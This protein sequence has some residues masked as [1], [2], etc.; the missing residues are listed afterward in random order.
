MRLFRASIF[1][2]ILLLFS[3]TFLT[4]QDGV[5]AN[6]SP[7]TRYGVGSIANPTFSAQQMMGGWSAA[8]ASPFFVNMENPAS[9]GSLGYTSFES[10]MFY[11]YSRLSSDEATADI[12]DGNLLHLTLAF[13]IFNPINRSLAA[14]KKPFNWGMGLSLAPY[15]NVGY[16]LESTVI[17]P[18]VGEVIYNF[19]GDGQ[20]YT[21]K[22]GNG[23]KYKNFSVGANLGYLFGKIT[24]TRI[25][26]FNDV[27]AALGNILADNTAHAGFIWDFGVQQEFNLIKPDTVNTTGTRRIQP[28][29]LVLGLS[30]HTNLRVSTNSESVYRR[31]PN[32]TIFFAEELEG[33]STFPATIN[34]GAAIKK[35]Q[36]FIIGTEIAYSMW[37][38]FEHPTLLDE[39]ENGYRIALGGSYT[40]NTRSYKVF[41]R[42]KYRAGVFYEKDPRVVGGQQLTNLG[43]NVGVSFPVILPRGVPSFVNLGFEMGQ[44]SNDSLSETYFRTT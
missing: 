35:G 29:K 43:L 8:Y 4:A 18:Q 17:D 25:A 19:Q 22:L 27:E 32:D 15:S 37:S 31:P 7:F 14:K 24:Q 9:L 42:T 26:A 3:A 1:S 34:F 39:L 33:P 23:F 40:P 44:L 12:Q 11:Q 5:P 21:M 30:G 38:N 6:N 36:K 16:D 41:K 28:T 13:P 10:G 2:I 20:L